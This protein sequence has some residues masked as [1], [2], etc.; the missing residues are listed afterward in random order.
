[1]RESVMLI[2]V[3]E[4][5]TVE[6]VPVGTFFYL[7]PQNQELRLAFM[8]KQISKRSDE[9][10][11]PAVVVFPADG[12]FQ[13]P[14][15]PSAYQLGLAA[16][17]PKVE[18]V[19]DTDD[20][21]QSSTETLGVPAGLLLLSGKERLITFEWG[22]LGAL[23]FVNLDTGELHLRAD[24]GQWL[25]FKKWQLRTPDGTVLYTGKLA[26]PVASRL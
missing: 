17:L 26:D 11:G 1:M 3:D 6:D 21:D 25:S 5:V 20:L 22:E 16:T 2:S 9:Y 8:A 23:N 13:M 14:R 4:V 12:R 7:K 19:I 15:I 24:T 18:V 10:T